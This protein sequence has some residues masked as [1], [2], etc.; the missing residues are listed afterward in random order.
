MEEGIRAFLSALL[1]GEV[2][3]AEAERAALLAETPR[4]VAASRRF[5][6]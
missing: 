2:P 1:D 3:V 4:R 6:S 5:Q